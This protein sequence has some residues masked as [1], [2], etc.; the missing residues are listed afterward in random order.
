MGEAIDPENIKKMVNNRKNRQEEL[1]VAGFSTWEMVRGLLRAGEIDDALLLI[2]QGLS[3]VKEVHHNLVNSIGDYLKYLFSILPE[4]RIEMI[5][6]ERYFSTAKRN[7]QAKAS[8]EKIMLGFVRYQRANNSVVTI[9]D[10]PDRYVVTYNPCGSG[11]FLIKNRP[12]LK[13]EKAYA[14]SWSKPGVSY[15]CLHC[16][17]AWEIIP[18]ELRGYPLYIHLPPEHPD[19]PCLQFHYKNP[20]L[21]PEEYFSRIGKSKTIKHIS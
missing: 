8:V 19:A 6:R 11:G 10:E 12:E 13:L 2:D 20:E 1:A 18:T 16:C 15:Y 9:K 21:I 17:I 5:L 7:V 4:E 3:E 14:W